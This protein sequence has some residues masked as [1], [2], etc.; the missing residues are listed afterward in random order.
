MEYPRKEKRFL[1]E[2]LGEDAQTLFHG[3]AA[4]LEEMVG[5][6]GL[7]FMLVPPSGQSE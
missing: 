4:R 6:P 2:F 3:V 7:E 5:A 1:A